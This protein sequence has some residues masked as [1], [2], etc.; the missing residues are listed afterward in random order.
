MN[1]EVDHKS[2]IWLR[3]STFSC[4]ST[5]DQTQHR[6]DFTFA[7]NLAASCETDDGQSCTD[8]GKDH[9]QGF[10]TLW[11]VADQRIVAS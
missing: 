9:A 2:L 10:A 8:A 11:Q 5:Q 4:K 6:K 1:D 3:H 7:A